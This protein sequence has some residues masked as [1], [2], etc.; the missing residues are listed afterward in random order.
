MAEWVKRGIL[1][2][3]LQH[4]PGSGNMA[5][6][7]TKGKSGLDDIK[8]GSRWQQGPP[9]LTQ[10]R[11]EWPASQD[12]KKEVPESKLRSNVYRSSCYGE[13]KPI[14]TPEKK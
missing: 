4:W 5:D 3:S 1:V 11:E 6:L 13:N 8:P 12:F 14:L 7:A 9:E 10:L 2:D